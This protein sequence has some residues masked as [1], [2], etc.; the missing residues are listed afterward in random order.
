VNEIKRAEWYVDLVAGAI[1][2]LGS[3]LLFGGCATA[4]TATAATLTA[5]ERTVQAAV[6]QYPPFSNAKRQAIVLSA[7]SLDEGVRGLREW[8]ETEERVVMAIE[9]AHASVLLAAD[10][11]KGVR[12]GLRKPGELQGWIGPALRVGV[13]LV[14]LLEAVGLKLKL[15]GQ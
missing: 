2:L 13:D 12:E 6:E 10:G 4:Y 11:L 5:A 15:G 14:R 3:A 1:L 7:K 9:G 8:D